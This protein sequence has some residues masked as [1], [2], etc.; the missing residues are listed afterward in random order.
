M[1]TSHGVHYGPENVWMTADVEYARTETVVFAADVDEGIAM[2]GAPWAVG[3]VLRSLNYWMHRGKSLTR[4][5]HPRLLSFRLI[6]PEDIGTA[7]G[8]WLLRSW[9]GR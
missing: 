7:L 1:A 5:E 2:H 3:R 4:R 9:G 6:P 8:R